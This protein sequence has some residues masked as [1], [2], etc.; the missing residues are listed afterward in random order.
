MKILVS[1][2]MLAHKLN[3]FDFGKESI[4]EVALKG[5]YIYFHSPSKF[6]KSECAIIVYTGKVKQEDRR[7]DWVKELLN[8]ADEQPV[9]LVISQ[10]K[11]DV[12]F[13]Y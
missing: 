8:K 5:R 2:K 6:V 11:I 7:W 4:E 10:Q 3:Q 9:V 12:I 13:Q 1:S